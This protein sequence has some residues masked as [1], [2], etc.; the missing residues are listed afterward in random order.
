MSFELFLQGTPPQRTQRSF[1]YT[2]VYLPGEDIPV[3]LFKD[4]E[5]AAMF[6]AMMTTQD[7][8]CSI[9]PFGFT[10]KR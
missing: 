8:Y 3:A 9:R 4:D 10:P 7:V 6:V 1:V 2:A 5:V